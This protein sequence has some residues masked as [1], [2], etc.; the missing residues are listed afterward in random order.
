MRGGSGKLFIYLFSI[1]DIGLKQ[2]EKR[3]FYSFNLELNVCFINNLSDASTPQN[4][5]EKIEFFLF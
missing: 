4:A 3:E 5:P 2:G 1:Y